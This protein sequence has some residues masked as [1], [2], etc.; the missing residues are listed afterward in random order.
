MKA[1]YGGSAELP[2]FPAHMLIRTHNMLD[3]VM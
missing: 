3:F 1:V 2:L